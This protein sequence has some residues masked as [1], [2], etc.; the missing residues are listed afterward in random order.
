MKEGKGT[1]PVLLLE[2]M[3]AVQAAINKV[4]QALPRLRQM[5][6]VA[7]VYDHWRGME[8]HDPHYVD[9]LVE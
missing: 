7:K 8:W 9:E 2:V 6:I 4:N 1:D 5:E 3:E